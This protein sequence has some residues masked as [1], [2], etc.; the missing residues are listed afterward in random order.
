MGTSLE[1]I[2]TGDTD[3]IGAKI[4]NQYMGSIGQ[5]GS[6]QKRFSPTSLLTGLISKKY[7]E[8]KKLRHQQ[9]IIQ[10]KMGCRYKQ[11]N[12]KWLKNI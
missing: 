8:L 2:G 1:R 3:R 5:I 9:N 6:F 7:K 11:R 10:S 4:K 12:L